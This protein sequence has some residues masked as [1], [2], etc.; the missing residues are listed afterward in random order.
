MNSVKLSGETTENI[1]YSLCES[2]NDL[3]LNIKDILGV[4]ADTTNAMFGI[5]NSV[6]LKI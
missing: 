1:F 5:N 4:A 6:V 2:L 3:N